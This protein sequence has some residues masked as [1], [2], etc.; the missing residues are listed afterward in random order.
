[1]N[2]NILK[3][4]EVK[5]NYRFSIINLI[6]LFLLCYILVLLQGSFL[7]F[8]IFFNSYFNLIFI[9]VIVI[10]IIEGSKKYFAFFASIIGG[11][12]L[13]IFYQGFLGID[14]FGINIFFLLFLSILIKTTLSYVSIK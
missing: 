4:K 8:F 14:F 13:D 2:Y 5:I 11:F 3:S 6:I 1:M 7:P 10:N 12:L 9:L